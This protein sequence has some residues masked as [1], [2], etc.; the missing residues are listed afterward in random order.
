MTPP[1]GISAFIVC[2]NEAASIGRC[3][4]SLAWCDEIVV[5][6]SGSTDATM[7]LCAAAACRIAHRDWTGY[8]DQKAH[9]LSLCTQP[10]ILNL[11]AD[12]EVSPELRE[13]IRALAHPSG[14]HGGAE[15][16]RVNK[17]AHIAEQ[18][19]AACELCGGAHLFKIDLIQHEIRQLGVATGN[20]NL[21]RLR[22]C[23]A[24]G[25]GKVAQV[26]PPKG[27][28]HGLR[29]PAPA[30]H[31]KALAVC[32][33]GLGLEEHLGVVVVVFHLK[34]LHQLALRHGTL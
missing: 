9:A 19:G 22:H 29:A 28:A 2:K 12:E 31:Q 25:V 8:V 13:E 18:E 6:D 11:D 5:V 7:D 21:P 17:Q 24:E 14:A 15:V 4:A 16:G 32:A 27:V 10:W 33:H 3:L 30:R 34:Y 1:S 26:I 20:Q 23:A